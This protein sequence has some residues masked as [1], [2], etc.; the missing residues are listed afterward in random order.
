M[1]KTLRKHGQTEKDEKH[2]H[3]LV[4]TI[5]ENKKACYTVQGIIEDVNRPHARRT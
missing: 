4:L 3:I 2:K 1:R 5:L